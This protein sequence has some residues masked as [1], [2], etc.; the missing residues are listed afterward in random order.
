MLNL[1]TTI[2]ATIT[3][4]TRYRPEIIWSDKLW[5]HNIFRFYELLFGRKYGVRVENTVRVTCDKNG[6]LTYYYQFFT[7]EASIAH[8]EALIRGLIPEL[9]FV[10]VHVPILALP[11]AIIQGVDLQLPYLFAVTYDTAGSTLSGA[12]TSGSV[13]LTI[14]GSDRMLIGGTATRGT[15]STFTYNAV[16]MTARSTASNVDTAKLFSMAGPPTGTNS[17]AGTFSAANWS[18]GAI[19]VTGADTTLGTD[20]TATGSSSSVSLSITAPTNGMAIDIMVHGQGGSPPTADG[21]NTSRWAQGTATVDSGG[22]S[23]AP[24]TGSA[25]TMSWNPGGNSIWAQVAVPITAVA[26]PVNKG[27]LDFF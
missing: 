22:Q 17:L 25:M 19:N 11:G 6:V 24:G 12:G 16:A 3:F 10:R 5:T 15:T 4:T 23:T 20:V 21:A 9:K 8:L 1:L 14:A 27:L 26:A 13:N 18:M 2:Y 7:F